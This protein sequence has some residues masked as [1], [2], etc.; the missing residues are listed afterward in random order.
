MKLSVLIPCYN[1]ERYIL[2]VIDNIFKN[3]IKKD[4]EIIITDDCSVDNTKKNWKKLK[5]QG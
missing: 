3:N 1:E 2:T 5:I 4:L